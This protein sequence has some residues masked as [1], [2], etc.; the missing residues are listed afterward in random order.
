MVVPA[1]TTPLTPPPKSFMPFAPVPVTVS[2]LPP[3]L[4]NRAPPNSPHAPHELF[5]DSE[6]VLVQSDDVLRSTAQADDVPVD[7]REPFCRAPLVQ[8]RALTL[9]APVSVPPDS[10]RA[11]SCV[12]SGPLGSVT[13]NVPDDTVSRLPATGKY[14]ARTVTPAADTTALRVAEGDM[15]TTSVV[16]GTRAGD[17]LPVS[18]QSLLEVPFQVIVQV[19]APPAAGAVASDTA[20]TAAPV[21]PAPSRPRRSRRVRD[22]ASMAVL[23]CRYV[24]AARDGARGR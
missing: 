2:V 8:V 1:L 3:A 5:Q 11:V 18:A 6:P 17:Q 24:R 13:A 9:H 7:V 16:V 4:T 10:V 19:G 22:G 21:T 14:T 23:G 20:A 12:L 15:H